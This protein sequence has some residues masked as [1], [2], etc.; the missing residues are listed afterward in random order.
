M[1]ERQS[2]KLKVRSIPSGGFLAPAVHLT[3]C[4]CVSF[5]RAKVDT[6]GIEPRAS[7]MLSGCDTTTP[8]ALLYASVKC[9]RGASD[10]S[11]VCYRTLL[12]KTPV[13]QGGAGGSKCFCS[14]G[15]LRRVPG[16]ICGLVL[17]EE[18]RLDLAAARCRCASKA[19]VCWRQLCEERAAPGIEPRTSRT[20][21][22]NHTTR[23]S[24]RLLFFFAIAV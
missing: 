9:R 21:S 17:A 11:H 22:E 24:S 23:P 10:I 3:C 13:V 2:C 20:L 1:V 7:R 14:G 5:H 4:S 6:L 18:H 15:H 12:A 8:C 16:E 19:N